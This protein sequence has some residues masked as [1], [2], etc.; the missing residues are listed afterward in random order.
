MSERV[1][2]ELSARG[3]SFAESEPLAKHSSFRIGGSARL[4]VFPASEGELLFALDLLQEEKPLVVGRGSNLVFPD[5]D[6]ARPVI[7]TEGL[8]QITVDGTR[9]EAGAGAPLTALCKAA[10]EAS[11]AGLA[12]AYGIP[13]SVGGGIY[14][15]AGA[16]GGELG[17]LCSSVRYYDRCEKRIK[18]I[19]GDAC[20]FAYRHSFFADH[21]DCVILSATF[22]LSQGNREEIEAEMRDFLDRRK[23]SQPLEF[24]SAGSAFRRPV[25]AYAGRLIEDCGLKGASVGGAQVSEKHAGFIVNRGGATAEDVRA[26]VKQIQKTVL[27]QTGFDLECEIEFL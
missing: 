25:G 27:E 13:G 17:S 22:L 7:F 3:I 12:F 24:P 26:L 21:K 20:A 15:N 9:I 8:R 5:G 6:F 1:T 23:A 18:T 16:Y 4:A 2:K 10:C 19:D 14:M 11:L